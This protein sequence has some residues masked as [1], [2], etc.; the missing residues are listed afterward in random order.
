MVV[1]YKIN[2]DT[3][4]IKGIVLATGYHVRKNK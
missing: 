2:D 1:K 3:D 4:I